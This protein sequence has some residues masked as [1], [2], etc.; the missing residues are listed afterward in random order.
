[1]K[2]KWGLGLEHSLIGARDQL[3]KLGKIGKLKLPKVKKHIEPFEIK[4]G[5]C[6]NEIRKMKADSIDCVITSPPYWGLRDYD[7]KDQIGQEKTPE[8]Y[9]KTMV[10]VFRETY[11]V[12]KPKGTLWLN[13]GD[14]YCGS[15]PRIT[16][17]TASNNS[18]LEG[19]VQGKGYQCRGA[20]VKG[21]KSKDL[22]GVP[23]MLAFALRAEGWYLRS[24]IIWHKP[25]HLPESVM[26]RP[27]KSHEYIFLLTKSKEYFFDLEAY[28]EDL[29]SKE[30]KW[31]NNGGAVKSDQFNRSGKSTRRYGKM[32]GK[33]NRRTV[34]SVS[35][36]PFPGAHF[37]TYPVRLVEPC[38]LAGCPRGGVVLD[39]F[40]GAGT[41]G[42]AALKHGRNYIGIELNPE[43]VELS[44]KR[45]L[46]RF[47]P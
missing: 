33:K 41:T 22:V 29:S 10:K 40:S 20:K 36:T 34:W 43:W 45:I 21:L 2:K 32:K 19:G 14:T 37:A 17:G 5:D 42:I 38:V 6:L 9:I 35:P 47:V 18:T 30:Q 23:W 12:L 31:A 27:T 24:D 8:E 11:R 1:L 3:S 26:D 39:P 28:A 15:S 4:R 46:Q 44:R 13:I 7:H 16:R 25:S